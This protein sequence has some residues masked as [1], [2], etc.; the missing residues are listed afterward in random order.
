MLRNSS[1][2]IYVAP[3]PTPTN[4][5]QKPKVEENVQ[6][7]IASIESSTKLKLIFKPKCAK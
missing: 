3:T 6:R 7:V 2:V 5:N 1:W 4:N